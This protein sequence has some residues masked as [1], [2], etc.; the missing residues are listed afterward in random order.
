MTAVGRTF[1]TSEVAPEARTQA[2][3]QAVEALHFAMSFEAHVQTPYRGALRSHA[4]ADFRLISFDEEQCSFRREP[5]HIRDDP[6][7]DIE[8]VS[9]TLGECTIEQFGYVADCRVG[10]FVLLD[11]SAPF[12][13]I[14]PK[15]MSALMLKVS[16]AE[17][18]RR[19]PDVEAICGQPIAC[20]SGLPRL[21]IDLFQSI[22]RE[23]ESMDDAEFR[24]SCHYLVDLLALAVE[25]GPHGSKSNSAVRVATFRRIKL[26]IRENALSADFTARDIATHLN[27]SER[28][29]QSLFQD[30]GTTVR[31][32][33][34]ML[35]LSRAQEMLSSPRHNRKSITEIAYECGFPNSA[36]FSTAFRE[37]TMQTP[38]EYRKSFWRKGRCP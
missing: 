36:Y 34:K 5:A 8:L 17:I 38:T 25:G 10:Q 13:I 32:Y 24:S 3:C 16:R 11:A 7:T 27:I 6:S 37:Q 20:V 1:S 28:Y 15:R 29:V 12:R 18:E 31:D 23:S 30:A 2:W 22:E 4:T 26:Y 19:F 9:P 33:I 14:Q 35:R 21:T